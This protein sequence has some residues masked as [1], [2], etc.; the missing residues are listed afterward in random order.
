MSRYTQHVAICPIPQLKQWMVYEPL[1]YDLLYKGSG[2]TITVPAWFR[3]DG[4][5]VPSIFGMLIQKVE[6]DTIKAACIHDWIYKGG[7][8]EVL[9]IY[10][11]LKL[12]MRIPRSMSYRKFA[13]YHWFYEPLLIDA[14]KTKAKLM[15]TGVRIGGWPVWNKRI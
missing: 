14:N 6:P 7:R 15:Y 4:A 12:Q 13:D 5:S 3:F 1:H 8:D 11:V 10:L 9:G 2:C